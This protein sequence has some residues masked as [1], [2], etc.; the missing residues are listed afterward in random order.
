[1]S[2]N[3]LQVEIQN[4]VLVVHVSVI[5]ASVSYEPKQKNG[6]VFPVW[7]T[8]VISTSCLGGNKRTPEWND[9]IMIDV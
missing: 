2:H 1:M 9:M 4:Q 7:Q 6:E 3:F 5:S 8:E